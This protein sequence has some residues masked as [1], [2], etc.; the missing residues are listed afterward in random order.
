MSTVARG[1][2]WLTLFP[3]LIACQKGPN[4][5]NI[6][7]RDTH[8]Y[9]V[10]IQGLWQWDYLGDAASTIKKKDP[11]NPKIE[12]FRDGKIFEL[13]LSPNTKANYSSQYGYRVDGGKITI[14]D[15]ASSR[16]SFTAEI[17]ELS[18]TTLLLHIIQ[19]TV[20]DATVG[21][22]IRY[23]RIQKSEVQQVMDEHDKNMREA[24]PTGIKDLE[25]PP[26][27]IPVWRR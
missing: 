11:A 20:A 3:L 25:L 4:Q 16:Q 27:R 19:T 6:I 18:D 1:C 8:W 22:Y 2:L 26:V 14:F 24:K 21:T 13:E 9:P 5:P 12:E 7:V 17:I 10:N 23:S 15:L